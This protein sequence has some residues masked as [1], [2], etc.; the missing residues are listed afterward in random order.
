MRIYYFDI[1]DGIP[2]RDRR[3]IEFPSAAAAIAHSKELAR[4]LRN[5]PRLKDRAL[6][7]VVVDE[8][9]AEVHRE[10]VYSEAGGLGMP[11]HQIENFNRID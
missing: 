5:E 10:P 1:K 8:S 9:G 2:T 6:V 4:L 11:L 3:G 7:I